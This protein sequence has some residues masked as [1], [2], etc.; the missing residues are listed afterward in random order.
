[1]SLIDTTT[2]LTTPMLAQQAIREHQVPLE[3]PRRRA[4]DQTA[5][6]KFDE[7]GRPYRAR[8]ADDGDTQRIRHV[9]TARQAQIP[10]PQPPREWP[11]RLDQTRTDMRP[12]PVVA[13]VPLDPRET[14]TT[15][16]SFAARTSTALR[17]LVA[18]RG[19]GRR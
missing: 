7:Y 5:E 17:R 15:R 12:K 1:M 19:W 4:V 8:H 16:L 6:L 10:V 3:K 13:S 18:N 14:A 2:T 9:A 11:P